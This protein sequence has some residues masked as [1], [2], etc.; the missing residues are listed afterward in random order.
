MPNYVLHLWFGCFYTSLHAGK[1]SKIGCFGGFLGTIF[2]GTFSLGSF[3]PVYMPEGVLG[4]FFYLIRYST[5]GLS[6]FM[7]DYMTE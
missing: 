5:L 1:T 6:G 3:T 2:Y 7:P 4:V